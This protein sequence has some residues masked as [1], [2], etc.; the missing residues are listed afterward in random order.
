MKTQ[1][2]LEV[3]GL[4][5]L[6]TM[7]ELK[8]NYHIRA[9]RYH[10]DKCN[11][12]P[13]ERLECERKFKELTEAYQNLKKLVKE[14]NDHSDCHTSRDDASESYIESFNRCLK[15]FGLSFTQSQVKD[16]TEMIEAKCCSISINILKELQLSAALTL[17]R[18]MA[19]N[20]THLGISN[21][22]VDRME[23]IIQMKIKDGSVVILR[24]TL[25]HLMEKQVYV[26]NR[27]EP[28][29]PPIHVPLWNPEA[30]FTDKKGEIIFIKCVP[31]LPANIWLDDAN[32][33]HVSMRWSI[34]ELLKT[35]VQTI[36][37]DGTLVE[38]DCSKLYIIPKQRHVISGCG[39]PL[40]GCETE[41]EISL[42]DII[43]H[44]ELN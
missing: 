43:V 37:L 14:N 1:E 27:E 31:N 23:E 11:G 19:E 44:I 26:L 33:I 20:K 8:K 34:N 9:L 40:I 12:T 24:P 7:K 5:K 35:P 22:M 25:M 21:T 4:A 39:I 28:S 2:A 41:D 17:Y 15:A 36:D 42:S 16:I 38:I 10:P 18:F 29:M 6:S 30:T 13:D 32:N 3:M